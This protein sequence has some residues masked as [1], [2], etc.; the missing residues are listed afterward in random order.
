MVNFSCIVHLGGSRPSIH[1][2]YQALIRHRL[3]HS[4][5]ADQ[6]RIYQRLRILE[7]F[8]TGFEL[9][10]NWPE[11]KARGITTAFGR[12]ELA[13]IALEKVEIRRILEHPRHQIITIIWP[14][15]SGIRTHSLIYS[16]E[17]FSFFDSNQ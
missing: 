12:V 7:I 4:N 6:V 1:P 10:F 15:D 16:P 2:N 17:G 9:R 5:P 3:L 11:G 13:R 8:E 14:H